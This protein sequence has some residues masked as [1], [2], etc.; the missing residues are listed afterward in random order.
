MT[1]RRASVA[2]A[3]NADRDHGALQQRVGHCQP[4][5]ILDDMQQFQPVLEAFKGNAVLSL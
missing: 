1:V 5:S 2:A 3:N 4:P